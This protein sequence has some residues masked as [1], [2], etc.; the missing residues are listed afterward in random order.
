MMLFIKQGCPFCARVI[1]TAQEL[2]VALTQKDIA[3]PTNA[4]E[5]IAR[6]GKQQTPFLVDEK[7]GVSMYESGD[8]IK[9]LKEQYGA[10]HS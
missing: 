10:K 3:D 7:H 2:G 1:Q 9:H 8:I 6:G 4:D 5:L